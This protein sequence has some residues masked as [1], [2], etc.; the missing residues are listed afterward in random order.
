MGATTRAWKAPLLILILVL[1]AVATRHAT[2]PPEGAQYAPAAFFKANADG[3]ISSGVLSASKEGWKTSPPLSFEHT[4][5][6]RNSDLAPTVP[7]ARV[8]DENIFSSLLND[9]GLVAEAELQGDS[10][11]ARHGGSLSFAAD[12]ST[13]SLPWRNLAACPAGQYSAD[14]TDTA[15]GCSTCAAGQYSAASGATVCTLCPAGAYSPSS[16]ATGCSACSAGQWALTEGQLVCDSTNIPTPV[17]NPVCA[18][19]F[20][21][22]LTLTA[23]CHAL[24]LAKAGQSIALSLISLD[25]LIG[26][27]ARAKQYADD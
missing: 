15:S 23:R 3:E 24:E 8:P 6:P 26:A 19:F 18:H 12:P 11:G 5:G 25:T 14:G 22:L 21:L 9:W 1:V 2:A 13:A 16:G 17:N 4:K 7:P 20:L 27:H 10:S